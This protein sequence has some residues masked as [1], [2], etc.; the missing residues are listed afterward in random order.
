MIKKSNVKSAL[1]TKSELEWLLGNNPNVSKSYGYKMKSEIRN[2]LKILKNLELPILQKSGIFSND[3]TAFGK[4][5]TIYSKA[6][7]CANP[8]NPLI[9]SQ[10]MVGRKGFEPSNP[11]MSRRYLNQARPPA[12]CS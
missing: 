9:Q 6:E 1:L 5:L 11:A 10:I 7:N 4:G 3:L 12:R 2:K 8:S